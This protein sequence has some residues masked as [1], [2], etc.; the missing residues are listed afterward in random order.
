MNDI[1]LKLTQKMSE[2]KLLYGTVLTSGSPLITEMLAQCGFDV[3]WLDMEHSAIGIESLLNNM[4]AARSGGTPAWVRVP[5]NDPVRVKPVIDMGADGVIF[6]FI[7][8]VDD[9]K[10]AVASC[11]FPPKGIRGY[12]PLRAL[13][14]GRI[15]QADFVESAY[16][17]CKR[18]IQ[19][20]H[21]DAVNNLEEIAAID[22]IDGYIV[23]P[24][25]L[26]GSIGKLGRMHDEEMIAL[27]RR[28]GSVLKAAGKPAGIFTG[29]YAGTLNTDDIERWI[30]MGYTMFFT[31][32]DC[33]MVYNSATA[34]INAFNKSFK[35]E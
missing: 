3:L 22:G 7:R 15:T 21:V 11:T 32:S 29:G 2:G 26:S 24:N 6:P 14:Y 16:R 35:K 10:L 33:G 18:I 20:E 17:D 19:I 9:A 30:D 4:I 5:W 23:G 1:N 27:Y 8:T 34:M 12:G 31:G 28:I 25:D 13:D